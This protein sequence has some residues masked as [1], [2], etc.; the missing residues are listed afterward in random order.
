MPCF[1]ASPFFFLM[2][3]NSIYTDKIIRN[4]A[5]I[6]FVK[7]FNFPLRRGDSLMMLNGTQKQ[8]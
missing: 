4:K 1:G 3:E 2:L 5:I 6:N 7:Y 8:G